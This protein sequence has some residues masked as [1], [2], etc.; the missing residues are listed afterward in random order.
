VNPGGEIRGQI[1]G[2]YGLVPTDAPDLG[3]VLPVRLSQ[4]VPNPFQDATTIRFSLEQSDAVRLAIYDSQADA[5]FGTSRTGTSLKARTQFVRTAWTT[6]AV[7]A[8]G[9]YRYVLQTRQVE[10]SGRLTLVR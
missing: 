3:A 6:L 4:S 7:V 8:S 5:S 2:F 9:V 1:E 10:E